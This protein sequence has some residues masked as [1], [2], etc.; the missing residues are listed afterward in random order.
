MIVGAYMYA[1]M[2]KHLPQLRTNQNRGRQFRSNGVESKTG[3]RI[4]SRTRT[5]IVNKTEVKVECGA[6][7]ET[8]GLT[9]IDVGNSI[10]IR[11]GSDL[12]STWANL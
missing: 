2:E 8:E 3:C 11:I 1:V 9:G 6:G 5:E 7:I 10:G 4:E 12:T